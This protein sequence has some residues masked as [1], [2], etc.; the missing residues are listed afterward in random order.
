M[1]FLRVERHSYCIYIYI[2]ILDA[3]SDSCMGRQ[4]YGPV[5]WPFNNSCL[6]FVAD[7]GFALEPDTGFAK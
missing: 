1:V 4:K 7:V 3:V 5:L 6:I 2:Y